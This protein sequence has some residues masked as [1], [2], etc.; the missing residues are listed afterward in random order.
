MAAHLPHEASL[1]E[2]EAQARRLLEVI[3]D[4]QKAVHKIASVVAVRIPHR[5]GIGVT[6][7]ECL[8]S[9]E[10]GSGGVSNIFAKVL[11][12]AAL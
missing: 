11:I 5:F 7:R 2:L 12:V 4:V 6:L 3:H 8:Q 1:Q 9:C 10:L